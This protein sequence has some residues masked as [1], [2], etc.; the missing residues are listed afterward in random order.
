MPGLV[1]GFGKIK[2]SYFSK[3][4][5]HY[6]QFNWQ[7]L[8]NSG[9]LFILNF[10]LAN[11][12][13]KK[14]LSALT[15][16]ILGAIYSKNSRFRITFKKSSSFLAALANQS[17][18]KISLLVLKGE[19][20][21]EASAAE[22]IQN[23]R[24]KI[25]PYLAGLIEGNGTIA[26]QDLNKQK[27]N[28]QEKTKKYSPKIIVVGPA[29]KKADLP[30]A[31]FLQNISQ[32]GQVLIKPERGYVL[33][34]IQDIVSLFIMLSIINGFMRTPKIEALNRAI[35]WLND[36]IEFQADT[37]NKKKVAS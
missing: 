30:L 26:V 21:G 3:N 33:W 16:K 23:L 20:N 22:R 25:G 9:F 7:I 36:Y 10:A 14:F 24:L 19:W 17:S 15:L 8:K 5:V 31:N 32:C 18:Q 6:N 2:Y 1:G 35:F 13:V 34:Q 4:S 28:S 37:K 29:Y 27:T 11:N 12:K